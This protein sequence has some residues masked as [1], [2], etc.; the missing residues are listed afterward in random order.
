[1]GLSKDRVVPKLMMTDDG[2]TSYSPKSCD[3]MGVHIHYFQTRPYTVDSMHQDDA[4][5]YPS[6]RQRPGREGLS[7]AQISKVLGCEEAAVVRSLARMGLVT[8][9]TA[10]CSQRDSVAAVAM[11]SQMVAGIGWI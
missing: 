2:S 7:V 6:K 5:Q 1:M 3:K 8:V 10:E 9:R 4:R 11:R